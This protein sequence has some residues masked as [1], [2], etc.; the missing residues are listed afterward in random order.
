[1]ITSTHPSAETRR[2]DTGHGVM[3]LEVFEDG[4]PPRWRIR[5]ESGHGWPAEA[6]TVETERTGG[7]AAGFRLC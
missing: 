4:V 1:M 6:V 3:A 7:D 2:I 5:T